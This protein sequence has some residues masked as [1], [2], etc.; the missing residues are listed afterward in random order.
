MLKNKELAK[1]AFI[2]P[3]RSVLFIDDQFPTYEELSSGAPHKRN[4][5]ARARSLVSSCRRHNYVCD[6]QNNPDLLQ[7]T[8]IDRIGISDLVVVDYHL[9]GEDQ[10]NNDVLNFLARLARSPHFNL[11]VL[12]TGE[13]S[14][15]K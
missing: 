13:K 3:V 5:V 6:V 15:K 14:L 9:R 7:A 4:E 8:E 11:A 12:Y 10:H 2:D 1:R